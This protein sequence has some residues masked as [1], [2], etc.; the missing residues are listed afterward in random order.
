MNLLTLLAITDR[1][2]ALVKFE[3]DRVV[4]DYRPEL[5]RSSSYSTVVKS[6]HRPPLWPFSRPVPVHLIA[7]NES[8]LLQMCSG[9]V[10][11]DDV[12]RDH[13]RTWTDGGGCRCDVEG[14]R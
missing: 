7:Y 8:T 3:I 9:A 2:R 11:H 5:L 10:W 6:L 14:M 12:D 4:I 13:C 1:V